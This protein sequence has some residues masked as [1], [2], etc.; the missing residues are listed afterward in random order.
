MNGDWQVDPTKKKRGEDGDFRHPDHFLSYEKSKNNPFS[1]KTKIGDD[2]I[3]PFVVA[4]ETDDLKKK[5]K[6]VW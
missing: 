6:Y 1:D 5:Q 4:D 2:D 3:V